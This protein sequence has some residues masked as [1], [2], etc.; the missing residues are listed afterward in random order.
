MSEGREAWWGPR[1]DGWGAAHLGC[2][3]TNV[4]CEL[5]LPHPASCVGS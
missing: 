2:T 4:S 1:V 3:A 5:C